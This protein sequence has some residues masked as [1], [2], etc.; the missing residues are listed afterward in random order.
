[1]YVI[2]TEFACFSFLF[3]GGCAST[4]ARSPPFLFHPLHHPPQ[5]SLPSPSVSPLLPPVQSPLHQQWT[6]PLLSQKILPPFLPLPR[7][8]SLP[9]AINSPRPP[10]SR[11]DCQSAA[12]PPGL[13]NASCIQAYSLTYNGRVCRGMPIYILC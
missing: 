11:M 2:S 6:H 12:F 5:P 4:L 9:L 8:L 3:T 13:S 10:N 1:M 7:L